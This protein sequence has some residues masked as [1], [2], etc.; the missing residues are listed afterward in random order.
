MQVVWF[1]PEAAGEGTLTL[2]L[3]APAGTVTNTGGDTLTESPAN[4]GRFVADVTE[5]LTEIQH[6]SAH[7]AGGIVRDGWVEPHR[8]EVLDFHPWLQRKTYEAAHLGLA[9]LTGEIETAGTATETFVL[10]VNGET[11]TVV[12]NDLT[13]AGNR[14]A[15]T[16]TVT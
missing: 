9:V 5:E 3:R 7:D 8:G 10:I 11:F 16:L 6:A 1:I 13:E 2:W 12:G 14:S 4:S 15:P